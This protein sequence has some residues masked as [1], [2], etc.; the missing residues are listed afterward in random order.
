MKNLHYC[1]QYGLTERD[2]HILFGI[3]EKFQE[4]KN[5]Y[6]YGSRAKGTFKSGSDIDLAI[7]NEN[8]SE[9]TIRTIKSE[10]ED[11]NLP[12]FVDIT[13]FTTLNHK[14]L[15]EHILRVG[16]PFYSQIS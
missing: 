1:F 14:E 12:Y 11:S 4:V 8:I 15:V 7:M 6:L 13:S 5:V 10:I 16:V 3:F 2:T 9:K